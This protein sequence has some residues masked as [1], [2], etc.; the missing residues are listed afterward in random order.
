VRFA[1]Y[2][3]DEI[4]LDE[5]VQSR[6]RALLARTA[7]ASPDLATL[8]SILQLRCN[9]WSGGGGNRTRVRGCTEMS[10]YKLRSPLNFAR[11]PVGDRPTDELA[12][13]KCRA[14]DEWLFF[15]AE[16]AS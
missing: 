8:E 2:Y 3:T 11:R 16:P 14:S 12:L 4:Q 10:V 15:G 1:L 9:G 5:L 6:A 13:L 7:Q